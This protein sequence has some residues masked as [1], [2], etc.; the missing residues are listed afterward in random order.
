[1]KDTTFKAGVVIIA[2]LILAGCAGGSTRVSYGVGMGYG[3]YY[4]HSPWRGHPVYVG[5]G[6]GGIGG[7]DFPDRPSAVQ[8]P[9]YGMPDAGMNDM[10]GGDFGDFG[11]FDD[12]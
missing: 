10:G 9:E 6:G 7:P 1:M 2:S 8:L 5:G 4:G 11:G 3:G 12:F